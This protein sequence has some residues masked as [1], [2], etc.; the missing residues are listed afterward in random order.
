MKKT[1][2]IFAFL[3]IGIFA[4]YSANIKGTDSLTGTTDT[5]V[6]NSAVTTINNIAEA[7]QSSPSGDDLEKITVDKI[8]DGVRQFWDYLNWLYI[9][10]FIVISGVFN[11]YV[12]AE[13]KALSLNKMRKVPMAV[14]V[15]LIGVLLATIF[16]FTFDIKTIK[17]IVSLLF[18]LFFA[19]GIYKVGIDRFIKY[20]AEKFGLKFQNHTENKNTATKP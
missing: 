16:V 12:S 9:V 17:G 4:V 11:M 5:T 10:A 8:W 1:L 15:L 14:W 3:L 13:N 2:S 20:L 7:V 19:M 18:S 6:A